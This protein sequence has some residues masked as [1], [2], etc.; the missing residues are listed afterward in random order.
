M[1]TYRKPLKDINGNFIIPAMTGD[2][3][4]WIQTGDIADGAVTS[5]KI[6]FTTQTYLPTVASGFS[7]SPNHQLIIYKWGKICFIT[8]QVVPNSTPISVSYKIFATIDNTAFRPAENMPC[9]LVTNDGGYTITGNIRQNGDIVILGQ[10]GSISS[11]T[12]SFQ[13]GCLYMTL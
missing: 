5:D 1:A 2:Q 8:G 12:S 10:S 13:I 7:N 9:V 11:I 3:T 4:E 6:D